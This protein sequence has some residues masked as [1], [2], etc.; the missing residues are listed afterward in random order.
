MRV[1][2]PIVALVLGALLGLAALQDAQP[3][4][5]HQGPGVF[6]E[7]H[8]LD[9]LARLSGAVPLPGASGVEVAAGV[10]AA[11]ASRPAVPPAARPPR[12]SAPRAPPAA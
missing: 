3:L 2:L 10:V 12:P 8:V 11:P 7:Q 6:D 1:R 4:H 9:T 5:V